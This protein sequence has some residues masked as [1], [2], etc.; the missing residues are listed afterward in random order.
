MVIEVFI[1]LWQL[2]SIPIVNYKELD[3]YEK[4]IIVHTKG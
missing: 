4:H 1:I 3:S 2:N